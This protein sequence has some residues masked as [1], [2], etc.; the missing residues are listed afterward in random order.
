MAKDPLRTR[1]CDMLGIEFPIVAFT[2]CKDVA[3]GV[4]NAGGF[5]VLG[6]GG[7]R[8]DKITQDIKWLRERIGSRPFGVDLLLPASVPP[9]GT[10]QDI[11]SKIPD[12][13]RRFVQDIKERYNIPDPK[14]VPGFD[15]VDWLSQEG[16]RRQVDV[17][18][19]ERVPVFASGLGSPAF[20]LEAAHAR[21]VQ[22]WGLIG[23]PRQARREIEAGVDAVI[24]QGTDAGGHTG[25]IGTFSLV[26]AVMAVAGDTPVLA[27]GGVT[28]G[29]HLAAAL[30]LGAVGVWAGTLWLASRESDEELVVKEKLIAATAEDTVHSRYVSG[31]WQRILRNQ[32]T[33]EW[34]GANAPKP[35]PAPY[36]LMLS[37]P[38]V[39][40]AEDHG[41]EEFRMQPSG[42]GV[43]F[44]TV[45][46]PVRQII[47]EMVNEARAAIEELTG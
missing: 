7:R 22:V 43:G 29:R 3:A 24:A 41:I 14:R 2:H 21:G 17:V 4:I 46:K 45:M 42:Q 16:P 27:A 13:H 34:E 31:F 30:S 33:A 28:T 19:E 15:R 44:V 1:L 26:P 38:I 35:L 25:A 37:S 20:V 47:F 6:E 8:P 39:Q 12:E 11:R 23:K 9:K 10:A 5:A 40:A 32:W 36:Q 18:L